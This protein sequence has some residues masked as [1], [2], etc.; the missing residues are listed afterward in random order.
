MED[1]HRGWC[2]AS[3]ETGSGTAFPVARQTPMKEKE[4]LSRLV[5]SDHNANIFKANNTI[6]L[7]FFHPNTHSVDDPIK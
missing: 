5:Q 4:N 2:N 7:N 1:E 6:V 3:R